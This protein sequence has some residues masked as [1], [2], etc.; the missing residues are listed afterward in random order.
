MKNFLF[1]VPLTPITLLNDNRKVIQDLCFKTLLLQN[2][3]N[4]QALLIGNELPLIANNNHKFTHIKYEGIK[5]EKLQIATKFILENKLQADYIIRLDDDDFFNPFILEEIANMNFDI[6]TDKFHT[7]F[8]YETQA[9]SQQIR[10]WFPNTCIHK[11][12]HAMAI[13][14]SLANP[15]IKKISEQIRLIENDHSK[16]HSYYNKKK[17]VYASRE[18]P[19]YFRVLNRES[20]TA[21]GS[22]KYDSYL[23]QFGYW[24]NKKNIKFESI[25]DSTKKAN[26]ELRYSFKERVYRFLQQ[27]SM[28]LFYNYLLFKNQ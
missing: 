17:I 21:K 18:N 24:K 25:Y 10:L 8:E 23:R 28:N 15:N 20:I 2:Y 27:V 16:I 26:L 5:E 12:E 3:P 14:G 19:L 13:F 6:Y 7:F 4:W 11:F 9:F 1:I 22:L